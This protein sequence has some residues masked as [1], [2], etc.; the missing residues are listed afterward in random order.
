[1]W[2]DRESELDLLNVQHLVA[3]IEAT[4]RT[5]DLLP[6]TV[7]VF[8][9][10]GSG[11]STVINL[12]RK[13][14]EEDEKVLCVHFNG[15]L[16]EG[17]EDARAAILGTLLEGLGERKGISGVAKEKLQ[18]LMT[19]VD[20]LRMVGVASSAAMAAQ[21]G[22]P[23]EPAMLAAGFQA[24]SDPRTVTEEAPEKQGKIRRTIRDFERDFRE[25]LEASKIR[26]VVV[27][28]DDLDRCLPTT[29]MATLEAI[30]LFVFVPRMAFVIAADERLVRRAVRQQFL[31]V[32]AT[33]PEIQAN[34]PSSDLGREYL[35]KL[36]Q[37]PVYV[38]PLSRAEIATYVN[39][40][41]AQLHLGEHFPNC[42]DKV[43]KKL[44]TAIGTE[45]VFSL[46]TAKSFIGGELSES[47]A[48]DL[49]LA[50]EV[51]N[52]LAASV[53]GNPRQTKR[54]LN[55]LLLRLQMAKAR[56]V[57]V[58]RRLVAKLML[59]EYFQPKLFRTLGEWQ[60][61][62]GGEPNEIRQLEAWHAKQTGSEAGSVSRAAG[63]TQEQGRTNGEEDESAAS[64]DVEPSGE[65]REWVAERWLRD[66]LALDPPL[67]GVDL[68]PYF[69][70]ARQRMM[71]QFVARLSAAGRNVLQRLVVPSEVSHRAAIRSAAEL[72][73][74]EANG[75]FE[76]LV[77][78][79]STVGG[80]DKPN[81][82]LAGLLRF[83]EVRDELR[84]ELV[85]YMNSLPASAIGAWVPAL[86]AAALPEPHDDARDAI[87]A[88]WKG[89]N[90]LLRRATE[91]AEKTLRT[92]G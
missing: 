1:M 59:L 81:S 89:G 65:L 70:F 74:V 17:Y 45:V 25:L 87:F 2:S 9:D 66:W 69:F 38:P 78:H 67:A 15:W 35:E 43:R 7:G 83:V 57:R 3:A 21:G 39:L 46:Q 42:C 92:A 22:M 40:L 24:I 79:T 6:V 4:V 33:D 51:G 85:A 55:A 26:S 82:A 10:W 19:R 86:L 37:V 41:F 75:V 18:A 73:M 54:F 72:S 76:S 63:E 48:K 23:P 49:S 90:D 30:R 32:T 88:R 8:G 27:F 61:A 71:G 28:I 20:W 84:G 29:I 80:M 11:K 53:R 52:V 16:F 31:D 64:G 5:E 91:M 60:A 13:A 62:Q 58:N 44:A 68:A 36:I 34:Y 50:A 77:R 47:L 56:R 12:A 14:L